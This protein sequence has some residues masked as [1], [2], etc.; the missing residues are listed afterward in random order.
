[1]PMMMPVTLNKWAKVPHN[2]ALK[3]FQKKLTNKNKAKPR[4][5]EKYLCK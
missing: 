2:Q 1:M 5:T 3:N 4:K